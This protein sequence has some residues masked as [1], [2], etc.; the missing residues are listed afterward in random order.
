M[1]LRVQTSTS[2]DLSAA[3]PLRIGLVGLGKIAKDSHLP[4]IAETPGIELIAVASRNA[5]ATGLPH[6]PD[7]ASMLAQESSLQAVVLCQPPQVRY[8]AALMALAAGKHVFLEKPPGATVQEVEALKDLAAERG[9]TL[10][11]SWH[12]RH[13]AGVAPAQAWLTGRPISSIAIRWREDVRLWHPGQE[14]IKAAGG[15]GVFD[16]GIN[17]LSILTQIVRTPLRVVDA[18]FETPINWQSP[19]AAT[20]TLAADDVPIVAHFDWRQ[21]GR[22]RWDIECKCQDGQHLLLSDGGA[23]L[24]VNGKPQ[25]LERQSEYL[26]LYRRFVQL[27]RDRKSDVDLSPLKIVADAFLCAR[28]HPTDVFDL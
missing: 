6:Y 5:A 1:T 3:P 2:E 8:A 24:S 12:S 23:D 17:A 16:P 13:A 27:A 10:F 20:L 11:A 18:V 15:F 25:S 26:G 4:A 21:A 19:I 7:L 9:V 14:W 22:Q 28:I